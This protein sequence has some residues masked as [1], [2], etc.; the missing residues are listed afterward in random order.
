MPYITLSPDAQK[1][2]GEDPTIEFVEDESEG[3]ELARD[4]FSDLDE[5]YMVT[6][7]E[8][9]F[10]DAW[11]KFQSLGSE[12]EDKSIAEDYAN[13]L[14]LRDRDMKHLV[15][16]RPGTHPGSNNAIWVDLDIEIYT[17]VLED[18]S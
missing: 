15:I 3:L 9:H 1:D 17:P 10:G 4:Y 14:G 11:F 12:S 16:K 18:V 6:L 7:D 13:A 8:V 5:V 2:W